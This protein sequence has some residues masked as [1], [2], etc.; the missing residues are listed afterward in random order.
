[1]G[2][3]DRVTL[4]DP[5]QTA[6]LVID[7]QNDFCSPGGC[8]AK[9][10]Y[11]LSLIQAML[12]RLREFLAQARSLGPRVV[13]VRAIYDT[14][15]LND[16][17]SRRRAERGASPCDTLGGWGAEFCE[18]FGPLPGG[19]E[20]VKHRYSA[21]NGTDLHARLTVWGVRSLVLT[22]VASNVCVESTTRDGFQYGYHPF[23]VEDCCAA[24]LA[25]EHQGAVYNI[26]NYFGE[27]VSAAQVLSCWQKARTATGT[28]G[29]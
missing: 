7:V 25:Q 3:A 18:G 6:I 5:C 14:P 29:R 2:E 17:M 9:R 12:P 23:F 19:E 16:P 10:G 20:V 22:G 24:V 15:S 21:F 4:L 28:H 26:R 13:F 8:F 1:M 11:D 27:V